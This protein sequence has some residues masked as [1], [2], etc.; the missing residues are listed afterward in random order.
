[1]QKAQIVQDAVERIRR[2]ENG[3]TGNELR[4]IIRPD[5]LEQEI[6]HAV[7]NMIDSIQSEIRTWHDAL[8]DAAASEKIQLQHVMRLLQEKRQ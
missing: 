6:T 3:P 5:V 7:A 2:P 4:Y 8:P 1:M